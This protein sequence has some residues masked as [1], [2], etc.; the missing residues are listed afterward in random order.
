M[1][2]KPCIYWVFLCL[3]FC[4]FLLTSNILVTH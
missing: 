3:K 1:R 4:K 2:G